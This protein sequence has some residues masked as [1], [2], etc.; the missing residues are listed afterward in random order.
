MT[1]HRP[2]H[3]L[4]S[5]SSEL[6]RDTFIWSNTYP[7]H[8]IIGIN[9]RLTPV[10]SALIKRWT[11]D[12]MQASW[13]EFHLCPVEVRTCGVLT[14]GILPT[15]PE[16]P[17][18]SIDALPPGDY[19]W[20]FAEPKKKSPILM[21]EMQSFKATQSTHIQDFFAGRRLIDPRKIAQFFQRDE[22]R[23]LFV[24]SV[25][26]ESTEVTWIVPPYFAWMAFPTSSQRETAGLSSRELEKSSNAVLM[27]KQLI[28]F[29]NDNAFN[30]DIDDNYHIVIFREMGSAR[31]LLPTHM[32]PREHDPQFETF[33]RAHFHSSIRSTIFHGDIRNEYSTSTILRMMEELG[34][35]LEDDGDDVAPMDD[36]RWQTMLGKEIWEEVIRR[37]IAEADVGYD[38]ERYDEDD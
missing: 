34:V 32:P 14:Y 30:V 1:D 33:L 35:G 23:C 24:G 27:H 15:G 3:V 28:P 16:I 8:L 5:I 31:S 7:S 26:R 9:Q 6:Q 37:R 38:S 20:Y 2:S 18:L 25:P 36:P 4:S 10:T 17:M 22:S 11:Q 19:G 29:F 21:V 13:K 12:I